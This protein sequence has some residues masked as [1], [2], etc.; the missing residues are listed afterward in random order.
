[1]NLSKVIFESK[2]G[3][4]PVHFAASRR[5]ALE[6]RIGKIFETHTTS[7]AAYATGWSWNERGGESEE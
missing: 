1:M 4:L 3:Y 6:C 5:L 2:N 7:K